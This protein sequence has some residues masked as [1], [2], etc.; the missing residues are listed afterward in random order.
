VKGATAKRDFTLIDVTRPTGV[1]ARLD[2]GCVRVSGADLERAF[3]WRLEA[4]GL[5][6]GDACVPVRD[7]A[8]LAGPEGVDLEVFAHVLD[9]PLALDREE[10]VAVL[11]VG[12]GE[13]R[14]ALA[15]LVA[16]DFELPDLSGRLHRL[17]DQRGRKVLLVAYASW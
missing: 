12:A 8:S 5:C 13:R 11:G 15:S 1:E 6:K 9:R 10:G 4:R 14:A 17:S 16:P 3:G 7:R 2:A